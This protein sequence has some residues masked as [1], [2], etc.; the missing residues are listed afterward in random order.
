LLL[1]KA[2]QAQ[3][4]LSNKRENQPRKKERGLLQRRLEKKQKDTIHQALSPSTK[5]HYDKKVR[6]KEIQEREK[7]ALQRRQNPNSNV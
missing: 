7:N 3:H 4:A 1:G 6:I 5:W 2:S